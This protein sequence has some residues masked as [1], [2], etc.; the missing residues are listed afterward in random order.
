MQW[1]LAS[2]IGLLFCCFYSNAFEYNSALLAVH[3]CLVAPKG[4]YFEKVQLHMYE[5]NSAQFLADLKLD[6][7]CKFSFYF[8]LCL[9]L[10]PVSIHK[11]IPSLHI[12]FFF[13]PYPRAIYSQQWKYVT[14]IQTVLQYIKTI[15]HTKFSRTIK[16]ISVQELA[17]PPS[18]SSQIKRNDTK[19][20][21][22]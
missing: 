13:P 8:T 5:V 19:Q 20:N 2:L 11:L 10:F 3:D 18:A 14:N 1:A 22:I 15:L 9:C 12:P 16:T 7:R 17:I 21:K 6:L 4:H